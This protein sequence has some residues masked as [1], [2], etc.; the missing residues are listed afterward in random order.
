MARPDVNA[1][2]IVNETDDAGTGTTNHAYTPRDDIRR[3]QANL[4]SYIAEIDA[5]IAEFNQRI[6]NLNAAIV[7]LQAERAQ[8]VTIDDQVDE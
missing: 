2:T 5:E 7:E 6:V 1:I 4:T 3:T 8:W